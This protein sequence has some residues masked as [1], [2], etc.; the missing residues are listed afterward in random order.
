MSEPKNL[1]H[2]VAAA[3]REQA[4]LPVEEALDD[5]YLRVDHPDAR[6]PHSLEPDPEVLILDDDEVD[7]HG[8]LCYWLAGGG[9]VASALVLSLGTGSGFVILALCLGA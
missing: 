6:L 7:R 8:M 5:L 3:F 4:S 1:Q 9:L 2:R